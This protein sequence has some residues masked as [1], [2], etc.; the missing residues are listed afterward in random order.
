MIRGTAGNDRREGTAS[1]DVFRMGPGD[2]RAGGK[3]GND[4]MYGGRGDDVLHG[5]PGLDMLD[6]G[7]GNDQLNGGAGTDALYGGPGRDQLWGGDGGDV[8]W[9][10]SI[11]EGTDTIQDF[12]VGRDAIS[13]YKI[14]AN[15]NRAGDQGF[16][17]IGSSAFSG[18]GAE[19]R[20]VVQDLEPGR[21][22]GLMT[23]VHLDT[24]GDRLPDMII[25]LVGAKYLD[26][27]D[28]QL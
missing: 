20:S 14:D 28:F 22:G 15:A 27:G 10:R 9:F 2:D 12:E 17:F 25:G 6:G 3:G 5:G 23:F 13:L 7:E 4:D 19:V 18:R 16:T 26:A 8:F 24:D 21:P 11:N 1:D